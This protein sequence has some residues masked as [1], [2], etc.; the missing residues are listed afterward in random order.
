MVFSSF[1]IFKFKM[2][3]IKKELNNVMLFWAKI[4]I[5]WIDIFIKKKALKSES[6][7]TRGNHNVDSYSVVLVL[8]AV[9]FGA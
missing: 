4:A 8:C 6:V 2:A 7:L 9:V 1:G 5:C 3:G